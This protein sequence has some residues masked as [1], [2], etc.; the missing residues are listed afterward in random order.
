MGGKVRQLAEARK[1]KPVREVQ[2]DRKRSRAIA[3]PKRQAEL[4]GSEDPTNRRKRHRIEEELLRACIAEGMSRE[5]IAAV[6][7][8]RD[9]QIATIEKRL[10]SND[11][12]RQLTLSTAHRYYIYCLQQEQC[13]RDLDYFVEA[14]YQAI[15]AWNK[16]AKLYGSPGVARKVL[17]AAPSNQGAILAIKAKS[18]ILDRTIK[19][20][21]DMG[22]I[23][24]RAKEVRVS[25]QLNLAALPTEQL[26][27]TLQKKLNQFEELVGKGKLPKQ[28]IKMLE[29]KNDV[30]EGSISGRSDEPESI[31][32]AEFT[33]TDIRS[34]GGENS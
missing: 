28:Y 26:K 24:K 16:A 9:D 29:G 8:L 14:S 19:M 23:Q 6:M 13:V 34:V 27:K 7:Q 4:S 2:P 30:G 22:I 18:E 11:G 32:D 21:Q 17:G 31:V 12:Q 1:Q 25:G 20:G 3:V 15:D 5:D 10:L 33:E